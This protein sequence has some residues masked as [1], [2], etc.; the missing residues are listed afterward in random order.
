MKFSLPIVKMH[1]RRW[2]WW[3]LKKE[4][5]GA[6]QAP[7]VRESLYNDDHHPLEDSVTSAQG[8]EVQKYRIIFGESLTVWPGNMKL[9][10]KQDWSDLGTSTE[11]KFA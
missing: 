5:S 9:R 6:L 8:R 2:N 11:G 3:S 4:D 7:V 10:T 1:R